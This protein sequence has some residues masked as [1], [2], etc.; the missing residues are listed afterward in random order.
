MTFPLLI[1]GAPSRYRINQSLRFRRS[2]SAHLTRTNVSSP[3]N[4]R[5]WTVSMWV[6]RGALNIDAYLIGAVGSGTSFQFGYGAQS[7]LSAGDFLHWYW[8]NLGG[9]PFN[10]SAQFRDPTSWAHYVIVY[11]SANATAADRLIVYVN[12]VRITD[13]TAGITLNQDCAWNQGSQTQ[14]IGRYSTS[15]LSYL[16]AYISE[17]HSIDGQALTPSSFGAFDPTTNSWVPRRYTGTYGTNGFYLPFNDAASTTTISQDR[18]GNANNWTSSGI[19]V[20]SGVTFDQMLDSP[21]NN[22]ATISPVSGVGPVGNFTFSEANLQWSSNGANTGGSVFAS[23]FVDSG[24]IYLEAEVVSSGRLVVGVATPN[25]SWDTGVGQRPQLHPQSVTWGG[26]GGGTFYNVDGGTTFGSD[27]FT[28]GDIVMVAYDMATRR[29][30]FGKNGTWNGSGNPA[31]GTNQIGVAGGTLGLGLILGNGS[32]GTT[33]TA[34]LNFGQRAFAY[35]PPTGFVALNTANLP[36]TTIPRGDDAMQATLRTGTGATASVTSL[37]FQPDLVWIKRRDSAGT[38]VLTDAVRGANAQQFSNQ[39]VADETQTN[40]LTAFNSNGYSLGNNN[41]GT[42]TQNNVNFNT[43]TYVDWAW[44]EGATYGFDIVLDSGT[45]ANKTVAHALNA[46]PHMMFRKCRNVNRSWRVYHRGANA[47]P[48]TGSLL[49]DSAAAFT[50]DATDWNNTVPTSS[51]FTVGTGYNVTGENY[52]TYLWTSIPGFSLFG[53]YTGNGSAD[54]PFVWCGFRPRFVMI[55]PATAAESWYIVDA[56][57]NTFNVTD[58]RLVAESSAAEVATGMP[59]DFTANG[60]KLRTANGNPSGGTVIF[61]A[62]AENPFK[63][64]NAR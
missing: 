57:R 19:S 43:A 22:Y 47:S 44:R 28:T 20:T 6:K 62:F 45:S 61:A 27:T 49:L 58:S 53:S 15:A 52:V 24:K 59:V 4:A 25:Q 7:S 11:D 10:S 29:V 21:T 33:S 3:T 18:S 39:A 55:K 13:I 64:A 37:R 46:V 42:F 8:N 54:G 30:W 26:G 60:F 32:S 31:A 5:R 23:Q 56:A 34:R 36:T 17:V 14:Y 16:D 50:V 2:N 40:A 38:H 9:F 12:G 51:V 48:A 41:S 1:G 35:T 63:F